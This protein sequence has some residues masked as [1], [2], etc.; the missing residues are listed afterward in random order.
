M[1]MDMVLCLWRGV[2]G[3]RR[4][5]RFLPRGKSAKPH[6]MTICEN[7]TV[8]PQKDAFSITESNHMSTLRHSY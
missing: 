2:Y 5:N 6:I 7:P 4:T 1:Q 8:A 3:S